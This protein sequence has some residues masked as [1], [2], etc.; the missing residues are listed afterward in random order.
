VRGEGDVLHVTNG[1]WAVA[2]LRE[3]GV[4]GDVLAWRDVL[5]EGP[6]RQGLDPEQLR[7]E[8]A[9]F[10]AA[11]AGWGQEATLL[12]ELKE[13]D[14]RLDRAIA[15]GEPIVL[16]FE[17]DLYDILQLAQIADR[18]GGHPATIVLVGV[19][20]FRDV[21]DLSDDEVRDADP[22]PFD[23]RPYKALWDA[24]R[25]PDPRGLAHLDAPPVVRDAAQRL[26][27][28]FPWTTDGLNRSER[29][30]V[31]ARQSG[32]RTPAE[33]FVVAQRQEERPFLGDT[34]AFGY[35]ERIDRDDR[36]DHWL[37]GARA[38][39]WR[40]DPDTLTVVS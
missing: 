19:E 8:R 18:L 10:L 16:W 22:Q 29:A 13:R 37:G 14:E 27:Q 9:R 36:L 33:A 3:A 39:D 5:H 28:Q 7:A 15:D 21:A 17:S 4:G 1:D 34:I 35:L 31:A 2:R 24:F 25:A 30:L 26:L 12:A 20:R 40:Y 32:A 11:Q 6:V 23:P 38:A